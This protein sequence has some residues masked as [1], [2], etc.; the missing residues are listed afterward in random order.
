MDREILYFISKILRNIFKKSSI[1]MEIKLIS[2]INR[3]M[4]FT[5]R[6]NYGK[7]IE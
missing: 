5:S 7:I 1:K 4:K 6:F 2:K 3:E